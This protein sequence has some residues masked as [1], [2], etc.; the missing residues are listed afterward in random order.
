MNTIETTI[1]GIRCE[2]ETWE[3]NG[4][5]RSSLFLYRTC[6]LTGD[7]YQGSIQLCEHEGGIPLYEGRSDVGPR[8]W[9]LSRTTFEVIEEWAVAHGY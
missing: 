5:P 2:L 6:P 7:E 1:K 8:V 4:E 3:E 9:E